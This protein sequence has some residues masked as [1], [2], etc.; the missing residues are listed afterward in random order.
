MF[1]KS[2]NKKYIVGCAILCH[3]QK[4]QLKLVKYITIM[5]YIELLTFV[6]KVWKKYL[7]SFKFQWN[8]LWNISIFAILEEISINLRLKSSKLTIRFNHSFFKWLISWLV[9]IAPNLQK[10][11]IEMLWSTFHWILKKIGQFF[12]TFWSF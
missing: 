2:L 1:K 5:L 10:S 3:S 9:G 11:K 6:Q 4:F 8:M 7:I 12:Q